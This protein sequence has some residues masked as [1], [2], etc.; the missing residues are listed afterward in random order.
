MVLKFIFFLGLFWIESYE[1]IGLI[2]GR[3]LF[4]LSGLSSL[5]GVGTPRCA[6]RLCDRSR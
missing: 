5:L 4:C 1:E 6:I 3:G 2:G